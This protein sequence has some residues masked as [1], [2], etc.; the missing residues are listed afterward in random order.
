M[1]LLNGGTGADTLAGGDGNDIYTV[2]NAGD[3]GR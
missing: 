2:D 1:T 3:D